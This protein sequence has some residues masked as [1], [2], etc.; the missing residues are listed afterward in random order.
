M[1]T[2]N[3]TLK[4]NR[5]NISRINSSITISNGG[6]TANLEDFQKYVI[7]ISYSETPE[8]EFRPTL[9]QMRGGDIGMGNITSDGSLIVTDAGFN[10]LQEFAFN[11]GET[12]LVYLGQLTPVNITIEY[13]QMNNNVI[14]KHLLEDVHFTGASSGVNTSEMNYDRDLPMIIGKIDF[15]A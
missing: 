6:I 9:G 15:K 14:V 1:P 4:V 3:D 7:G 12:S 11:A 13:A 2:F 8:K 10:L 5:Q